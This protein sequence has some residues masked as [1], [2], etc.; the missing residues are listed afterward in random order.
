VTDAL[1]YNRRQGYSAAEVAF[2]QRIVGSTP[3]GGWGPD[4]VSALQRWQ[5]ANGVAADGKAWR[6]T[7]GNTWP[8][9][10]ETGAAAWCQGSPGISRVGLWTFSD[11]VDPSNPRCAKDLEAASEAALTDIVFTITND[12]HT[13]FELLGT[14]DDIVQVGEQYKGKGIDVGLNSF[15]FP[16]TTYIDALADAVL[17]IDERLGLR[18]LDID[19]EEL[20]IE[21]GGS[22]SWNAAA[23]RL[24][25]RFRGVRFDVAVNGIVYTSHEALD[26]LVRQEC[27]TCVTPQAYSVAGQ[28]RSNGN[29]NATYNPIDLQ[30]LAKQMWGKWWPDRKMIGGFATYDQGGCYELGTLKEDVAIGVALR[31]WADLGVA[32]VCGW[33]SNSLSSAAI[34]RLCGRVQ[35]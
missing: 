19:A 22:S 18:R 2:I 30:A 15:V 6:S 23:D 14:I 20:W 9:L 32:E 27:V 26:P 24:G 10:L 11:A 8:R 13:T 33:S 34:G 21:H 25:A 29:P 1:T 3:D 16:S 12:T 31:S 17:A 4:T 5:S 7:S 35:T 28:E